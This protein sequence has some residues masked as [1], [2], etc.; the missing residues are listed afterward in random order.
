MNTYLL[1]NVFGVIVFMAI[2]FLLSKDRKNINWRSVLVVLLL[3]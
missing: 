3:N 1:V 2:A